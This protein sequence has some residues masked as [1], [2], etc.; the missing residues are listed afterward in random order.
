MQ[1][2]RVE[3][4]VG[5]AHDR[6]PLGAVHHH[7]QVVEGEAGQLRCLHKSGDRG[8][9]GEGRIMQAMPCRAGMVPMDSSGSGQCL[10]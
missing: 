8:R 10:N 6:Q 7:R 9:E 3:H 4:L 2:Q 1:P 5:A